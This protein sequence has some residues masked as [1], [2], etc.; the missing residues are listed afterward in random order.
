M[1]TAAEGK[2][3]VEVKKQRLARESLPPLTSRLPLQERP[4]SPQ[5]Q[6]G[7]DSQEQG[8]PR[9]AHGHCS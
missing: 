2:G 5:R 9:S 6:L 8:Q 7:H 1:E 3:V 4:G